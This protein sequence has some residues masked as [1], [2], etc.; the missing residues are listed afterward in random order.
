MFTGVLK[1]LCPSTGLATI[2]GVVFATDGE[3]GTEAIWDEGEAR[4]MPCG[5][6][7]W[8]EER[9]VGPLIA[10]TGYKG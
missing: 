6:F 4:S 5:R 10:S 7:G 9:Y 8:G 3:I 2:S 1:R